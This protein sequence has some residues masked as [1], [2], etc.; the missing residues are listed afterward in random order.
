MSNAV[1]TLQNGADLYTALVYFHRSSA[2]RI[3][4]RTTASF[5]NLPKDTAI[6]R[7]M[8]RNVGYISRTYFGGALSPQDLLRGHTLFGFLQLA[9]HKDHASDL[10]E[11]IIS[12]GANALHVSNVP[13]SQELRWCK[14]CADEELEVYGFAG[15]KVVHQLASVRIWHI[16]GFLAFTLQGLRT[17]TRNAAEFSTT[18]VCI[19][20]DRPGMSTCLGTVQVRFIH[21]T[22]LPSNLTKNAINSPRPA[23]LAKVVNILVNAV[24]LPQKRAP[25]AVQPMVVSW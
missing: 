7:V 24:R 9:R 5:L 3:S 4:K 25:A 21:F 19:S 18:W 12:C 8:G 6:P 13:R 1:A 17:G 20:E 22:L 2:R 16:N 23:A 15:W 11:S 14:T 10:E